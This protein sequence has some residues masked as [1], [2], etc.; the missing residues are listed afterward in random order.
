MYSYFGGNLTKEF[1]NSCAVVEYEVKCLG[2]IVP[3]GTMDPKF[4][5]TFCIKP[6]KHKVIDEK[7]IYKS[8]TDKYECKRQFDKLNREA[9]GGGNSIRCSL[10]KYG[11]LIDQ[12]VDFEQKK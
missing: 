8:F 3:S 7:I 4:E 9:R 6:A 5:D 11:E 2:K 12:F 1:Y 10:V